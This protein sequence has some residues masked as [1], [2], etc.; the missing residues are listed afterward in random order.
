M[1]VTMLLCDHAQVADNKLFINGAG[2]D[3]CG[4]PTPPH[5]VAI[6]VS[7]PWD[8]TNVRTEY[9]VEL[10]HEDGRPVTVEGPAGPVPVGTHG[11][12]E[13]GRP[14]GLRHG[15]SISVPLVVNAGPL[16]LQPDSGYE[17]RLSIAG[18]SREDWTLPFRTTG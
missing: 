14:T 1:R 8:R 2:W 11:A 4:T 16:A 15:S 7:V 17:W 13:V 5:S 9:T 6:L 3:L 18:Q 10:I 12:F